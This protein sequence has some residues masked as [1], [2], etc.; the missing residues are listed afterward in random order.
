MNYIKLGMLA[1]D[2]IAILKDGV[3]RQQLPNVPFQWIYPDRAL[4]SY[5]DSI[6]IN[7]ELKI[8]WNMDKQQRV[9]K[10]FYSAPGAGF[11]IHKD[12]T[13]C[14]SCLNIAISCNNTDWVRWYDDN[15]IDSLNSKMSSG[16]FGASRN[17]DI[18]EYS[19]IEYVDE[20][21]PSVGEVY[22]VN[23]D[24]YHSYM[25]NGPEPRMVMQTKFEG[26]PDIATILKSL[27]T[28]SF[29][30]LNMQ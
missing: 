23:T 21:R 17:V 2:V 3:I 26:F 28:A 20:Y 16:K 5:F 1:D 10:I 29:I 11:K 25:C 30:N 22:L 27:K 14:K 6:F 7:T 12:G 18:H 8:Q 15:Y 24:V 13:H 19:D 9:Q 4:A